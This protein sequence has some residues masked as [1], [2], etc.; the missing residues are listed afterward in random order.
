MSG[1]EERSREAL[2]QQEDKDLWQ[3]FLRLTEND[4]MSW[5]KDPENLASVQSASDRTK[6]TYIT[7]WKKYSAEPCPLEP[8]EDK[9]KA[10]AVI[11][12]REESEPEAPPES[13]DV[14]YLSYEEYSMG[15]RVNTLEY[16]RVP[17][18]DV[19][20]ATHPGPWTERCVGRNQETGKLQMVRIPAR[21]FP[22]EPHMVVRYRG[23]VVQDHQSVHTN[24]V[25]YKKQRH[26]YT[27]D[28]FYINPRNKKRY[29]RC[30]LIL[31]RI[32]QAGL[33]FEKW[34]GRDRKARARLRK[35]RGAHGQP[36]DE[37]MYELIGATEGDYRDL[38]RLFERHFL[39][40]MKDELADDIGLQL[41]IGTS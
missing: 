28:R 41:L 1:D 16:F 3:S 27:F 19:D 23:S 17:D 6:K 5:A 30:C 34:V 35:Q 40:S 21:D 7:K 32:H 38:K 8:P 29:D 18:H 9:P 33:L 10:P 25:V 11:S 36:L 14:E 24:S 20:P 2:S 39:R 13:Q 4:F 37:P 26:G 31:D 15:S 22:V 12:K